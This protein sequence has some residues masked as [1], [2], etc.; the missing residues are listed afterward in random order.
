MKHQIYSSIG[1]LIKAEGVLSVLMQTAYSYAD[2]EQFRNKSAFVI[3]FSCIRTEREKLVPNGRASLFN[4]STVV[5]CGVVCTFID[6][7]IHHHSGQNVVD[8]EAQPTS[9]VDFIFYHDI[10]VK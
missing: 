1:F 2:A 4:E 10:D 6:S 5:W 8:H 7:D 9:I 3:Y